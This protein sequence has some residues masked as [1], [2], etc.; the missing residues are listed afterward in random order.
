MGRS[1]NSCSLGQ[2]CA[3][4]L[5]SI[6]PT[7]GPLNSVDTFEDLHNPYVHVVRNLDGYLGWDGFVSKKGG[8]KHAGCFHQIEMYLCGV[9]GVDIFVGLGIFAGRDIRLAWNCYRRVRGGDWGRF[10]K[11]E[12]FAYPR[13]LPRDVLSLYWRLDYCQTR[14]NCYVLLSIHFWK[15]IVPGSRIFS[16]TVFRRT[17]ILLLLRSRQIRIR[18]KHGHYILYRLLFF[19]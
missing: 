8:L 11:G 16:G 1:P 9:V 14:V 12:N 18:L 13:S 10:E 3:H 15:C 7:R 19:E 2:A 5:Q 6:V 17:A 4:L